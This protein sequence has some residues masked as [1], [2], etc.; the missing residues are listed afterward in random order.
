[1]EEVWNEQDELEDMDFNPKTFFKL[2]GEYLDALLLFLYT[3][4]ANLN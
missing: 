4:S 2:H 1:M 3:Y